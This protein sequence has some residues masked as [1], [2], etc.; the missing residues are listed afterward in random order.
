VS[1]KVETSWITTAV[2]SFYFLRQILTCIPDW[3]HISDPPAS[4]AQVLELLAC[5]TAPGKCGEILKANSNG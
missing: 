4:A 2:E 1:Y 3:P 5:T